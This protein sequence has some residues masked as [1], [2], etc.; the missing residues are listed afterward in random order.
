[1][2]GGM[3]F[4]LEK[5][6]IGLRFDYLCR[7]GLVRDHIRARLAANENPFRMS[8]T[9]N[10]NDIPIDAMGDSKSEFKKKLDALLVEDP[11]LVPEERRSGDEYLID[12]ARLL[13][14]NQDTAG[15]R[16]GFVQYWATTA[17]ALNA[18][19]QSDLRQALIQAIDS[20]DS[21]R[22]RIDFWWDCTM[23]D[24]HPPT[25]ITS[26]DVPWIARV[27]FCTD[28][29]PIDHDTTKPPRGPGDEPIDVPVP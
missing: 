7:S 3:P 23:P 20:L 11:V 2:G 26:L 12:Q 28:H 29:E 19:L 27:L 1:M 6:V 24:H 8:K 4:H 13:G 15:N 14:L 25:V 5:G 18:N 21:I 16:D 17:P 22:Q 9:L 10:I